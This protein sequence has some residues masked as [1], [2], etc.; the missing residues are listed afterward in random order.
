MFTLCR[1]KRAKEAPYAIFK[2]PLPYITSNVTRQ[3]GDSNKLTSSEGKHVTESPVIRD[4][5]GKSP[6]SERRCSS[7]DPPRGDTFYRRRKKGK[8]CK[9]HR[10][11]Y[12]VAPS[13]MPPVS[14]AHT[15][16]PSMETGLLSASK[17]GALMATKKTA[18]KKKS[19]R[20][21]GR[22]PPRLT[23]NSYPQTTSTTQ[24]TPSLKQEPALQLHLPTA[25]AV[26]TREMFRLKKT[27]Q[28]PKRDTLKTLWNAT[29]SATPVTTKLKTAA[30]MHKD[31]KPQKQADSHLLWNNINQEPMSRT[32][33]LN[34]HAERGLTGECMFFCS[35]RGLSSG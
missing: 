27:I 2:S 13:Q 28:T 20:K 30:Y 4:P 11:R 26:T 21:R 1:C 33:A 3:Y 15:T 22:V 7:R 9:R 10:K 16:A 35:T 6:K 29:T 8:G 14:R 19:T 31:D 24:C 12:K 17:S 25:I 5:N 23:T 18:G 32:R 34:T